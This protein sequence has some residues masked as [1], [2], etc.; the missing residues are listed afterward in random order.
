MNP[1]VDTGL[2]ITEQCQAPSQIDSQRREKTSIERLAIPRQGG[3]PR[4][5]QFH[6]AG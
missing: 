1:Q 6:D 5:Y 2:L 4:P 3:Y